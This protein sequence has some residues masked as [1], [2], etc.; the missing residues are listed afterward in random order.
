MLPTEERMSMAESELRDHLAVLLAGR[1][2][3]LIMY[4]EGTV[5]AQNDLERATAIARRMVTSWGMSKQIGPVAFKMSDDDPFLGR[6]I[7]QQRQF[8]EHTM[9]RIDE[10]I[11]R[12]LREAAERASKILSDNRDKLDKLSAKLIEKEELDDEDI[13]LVLGPSVQSRSPA[14]DRQAVEV[15]RNAP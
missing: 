5:G 15:P 2:A 8:S 13:T 6:E 7:H 3:E 4:G 14:P 11:G 12:I 10:E 1:A 9:E